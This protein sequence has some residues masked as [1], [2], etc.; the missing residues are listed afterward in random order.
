MTDDD[1]ILIWG[2]P[3]DVAEALTLYALGPMPDTVPDDTMPD[4]PAASLVA[5]ALVAR[6]RMRLRECGPVPYGVNK[7]LY[8]LTHAVRAAERPCSRCGAEPGR[9][10]TS[11]TG[12]PTAAHTA[13]RAPGIEA[14]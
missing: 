5:A 3:S 2:R 13:R 1:R 11:A 10:C 12:K 8:A 9:W 4:T 14:T 6:L 7:A